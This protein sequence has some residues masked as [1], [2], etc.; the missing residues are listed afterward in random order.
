MTGAPRILPVRVAFD[1]PLPYPLNA[2]L[3][4]IQYATWNKPDDTPRLLKELLAAIAG[5]ASS[6]RI[7]AP[8]GSRRGLAVCRPP[9]AAPMPVP[10]GTLDVDD[11]WYLPRPT[12]AT[13]LAAIRQ[14]GQ[15]LTIKGPRQMGKSSLLMRTVKAALDLGKKVALLD[16]QLIDDKT[17]A[18]ADLFFRR[19]ATSIAEQFELPD[20]VDENWDAGFSNPQNCTR[21][22]ERQILQPLNGAVRA[23][24][25]RNRF[26]L[27]HVRSPRTSSPC[28]GAGT[29]CARIRRGA[30]GRRSTSSFRRRPNRSSSSI[31]RTSRRSTSASRCRSRT[32]CP[33]R[34]RASTRC[35]RGRSAT[36][37]SS[38]CTARSAAIRI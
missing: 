7:P 24:D 11:P 21:Y 17:K 35:T 18:D 13:A 8:A 4:S 25:R 16:F 12:D 28:F 9:Y 15:T 3:D 6:S 20:T 26:D 27:P 5:E 10:G 31:G 36:R 33:I 14:P 32:S 37:T 29:A 22:V 1:G 2:Y 19:F 38:G 34:S 23:R 30:A